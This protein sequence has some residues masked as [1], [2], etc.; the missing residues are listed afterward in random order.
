M[1]LPALP[2]HAG[3]RATPRISPR[4]LSS[5]IDMPRR[6]P[7]LFV[8]LRMRA[9]LRQFVAFFRSIRTAILGAA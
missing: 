9:G 4:D 6:F 7:A 5:L 8:A 3:D 1:R 2:F